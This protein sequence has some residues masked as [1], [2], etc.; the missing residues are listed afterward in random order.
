MPKSG[1]RSTTGHAVSRRLS[2][3]APV[4][5]YC[6]SRSSHHLI[7]C[8]KIPTARAVLLGSDATSAPIGAITP[9]SRP[10]DDAFGPYQKVGEAELFGSLT[11]IP[12][13]QRVTLYEQ[14]AQ[15]VAP[16]TIRDFVPLAKPA[17]LLK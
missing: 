4:S 7:G 12:P 11:E 13:V 17:Q 3:M 6:R 14:D 16:L 8:N 10:A 2:P 9:C 5:V 1:R 15:H